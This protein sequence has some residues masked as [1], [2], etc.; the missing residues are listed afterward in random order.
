MNITKLVC[1][2]ALLMLPSG[3][4]HALDCMGRYTPLMVCKRC[5]AQGEVTIHRDKPC[6]SGVTLGGRNLVILEQKIV[7][8]GKFGR[9][10]VSGANTIYVPGK[11]FVGEDHYTLERDYLDGKDVIV[12]FVETTVHVIP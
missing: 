3:A 4:A 10:G 1:A 9:A 5:T 6:M 8:Q 11:G 7:R 2:A 12:T